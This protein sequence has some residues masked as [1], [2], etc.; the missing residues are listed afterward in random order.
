[1]GDLDCFTEGLRAYRAGDYLVAVKALGQLTDRKGHA[2]SLARHYCGM[3]HRSLGIEHARQGRF[4]QAARHLRRAVALLG[5]RADLAEQLLNLYAST[6]QPGRCAAAAE[7]LV[8]CRRDDV[9]ARVRLAQ[10]QWREG[11]RPQAMMTLTEALR[12]LGDSA[13]AHLVM[14][15]FHAAGDDLEQAREHLKRA[16]V[17]E[18]T[19]GKAHRYLGLVESARGD[20]PRA[21][22]AFQR[23]WALD[24]DDLLSAYYLC[25]SAD[26]CARTGRPVRVALPELTQPAS[27]SEIRQLARYVVAEPQFLEAVLSAPMDL[28]DANLLGVVLSVLRTALAEH[29][30]HADL[31]YYSARTLER[32]GDEEGARA[33]YEQA[34]RINPRYAKAL[35]GCGG[36]CARCGHVP[37]AVEYLERAI[38][39][40]ADYP[41]V[42]VQLGDLLRDSGATAAAREHYARALEQNPRYGPAQAGLRALA[43]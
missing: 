25:V 10:A 43:A 22:A 37:Q 39:C 16:C 28:H 12:E 8:E 40:G 4:D 32:L 31:H 13:E 41:D 2:G 17:C 38:A 29:P 36:L 6:D 5:K 1:M 7:V 19:W 26:A 15:L 20:F 27:S 14:G 42:H 18:C 11:R 9:S 21:V 33:A 35:L 23:A 3:A 24:P 34:L 30:D